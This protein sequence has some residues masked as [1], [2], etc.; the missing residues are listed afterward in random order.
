M[1]IIS[2]HGVSP[3]IHPTAYVA[4]GAWIIGEVELGEEASVW[5]NA[6]LRGDIN[7]IRVGKR[8]NIQDGAVVHLTRALPAVIGD[9]VTVGHKAML[10][11]CVIERGCLI[12]MNAVVLDGARV[13]PFS[14]VAAGAV[15][16]E[17]YIIPEGMLAAGVPARVVR[18]V[19]AEEKEFLLQSAR[20][21]V[22]YAQSF[23]D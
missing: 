15:V 3:T 4:G 14:I 12:G 8:S 2:H 7:S 17:E 21:Y 1:G 20:N 6:V 19:T 23:R 10:H 11:A 5:F 13:G 18:P 9:D 16:R 22:G